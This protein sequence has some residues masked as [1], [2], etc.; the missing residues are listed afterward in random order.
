MK[1]KTHPDQALGWRSVRSAPK[2]GEVFLLCMPRMMNLIVRCRYNTINGRF[3]TDMEDDKSFSDNGITRPYF[4]FYGGP[5]GGRGNH[6]SDMWH[7][8]PPI[9]EDWPEIKEF[10]NNS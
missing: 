3:H 8:M 2:T 1:P 7:P 6:A 5:I 10:T 4:P 9:P